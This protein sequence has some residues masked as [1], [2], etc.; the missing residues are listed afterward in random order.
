MSKKLLVLGGTGA[1]GRNVV[2]YFARASWTVISVGFSKNEEAHSNVIVP[3]SN[4][5]KQAKE[6]METISSRYGKVNT[7]VS[8][9]GG[10]AGGSI[11]DPNSLVNLGDMHMKNLESAFLATYLASH[12]LLPGGLLVLTGAT[13]ALKATPSMVSYGATKAATHHLIASAVTELPKDTSVLGVLPATIDTPMNRKFMP[14][15]D[16]SSW[17]KAEDIAQKILEWSNASYAAR[18]PSGHL[19]RAITKNNTTSWQDA[20]NPFQ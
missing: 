6:T 8:T 13:A 10:W 14:D 20:G 9:A 18:P 5:L 15:A 16:F 2:S 17:T 4:N 19:I 3:E 12:L 11:R 7:V 1:L